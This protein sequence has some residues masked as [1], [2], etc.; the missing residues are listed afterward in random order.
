M[1]VEQRESELLKMK[2]QFMEHRDL[3][4]Q[5]L[6]EIE[7]KEKGEQMERTQRI[8]NLGAVEDALRN[9]QASL[10]QE[11][12]DDLTHIRQRHHL[13]V[14]V[15]EA[16]GLQAADMNGLSD[17][18]VDLSLKTTDRQI[19]WDKIYRQRHTT[20]VIERNLNPK[21]QNQIFIIKVNRNGICLATCRIWRWISLTPLVHLTYTPCRYHLRPSSGPSSIL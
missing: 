11:L 3:Y 17:P 10:D 15:K 7:A 14:E 19:K 12:N 1:T 8:L 4:Y 21:W 13:L 16:K 5:L 9:L 20:Y 2:T 18:F 6:E